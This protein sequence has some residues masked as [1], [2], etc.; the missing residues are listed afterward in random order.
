MP[1]IGLG[2]GEIMTDLTMPPKLMENGY[3]GGVYS[4]NYW[5][6]IF[7]AALRFFG[8]EGGGIMEG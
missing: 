3:R 6:S 4:N 5:E 8:L 7:H 2:P 1:V